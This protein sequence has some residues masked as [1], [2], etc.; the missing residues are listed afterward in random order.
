M[1]EDYFTESQIRE[2]K[3]NELGNINM[4]ISHS[5][6]DYCDNV[7]IDKEYKVVTI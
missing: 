3:L 5:S 7:T 4:D 2:I 1:T 6:I